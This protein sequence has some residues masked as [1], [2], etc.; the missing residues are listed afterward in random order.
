MGIHV[1][2]SQ[3]GKLGVDLSEVPNRISPE[4]RSVIKKGALET[5]KRMQAIFSGHRMAPVVAASLE[6]EMS[7]N[8]SYSEAR[9]GELDSAGPQWGLA[10]IYAFGTS[11]NAPVV[12]H[13]K[14]LDGEAE[15]IEKHLGDVAE[16]AALGGPE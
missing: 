6:F 2:A 5:K 7:G 16:R 11:N 4:A 13:T 3:V 10:A 1:D 15:A 9:I 12:D 14:A 8:A